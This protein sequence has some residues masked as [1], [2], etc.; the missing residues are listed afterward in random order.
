V[1][2]FSTLRMADVAVVLF[3]SV[4][5]TAQSAP[6]GLLAV[7]LQMAKTLTVFALRSR[8]G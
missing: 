7:V 4:A 2:A 6:R 5:L 1:G 3:S 8:S